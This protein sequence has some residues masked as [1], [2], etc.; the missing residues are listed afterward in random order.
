VKL[1]A[2]VAILGEGLDMTY[3]DGSEKK[4][5]KLH[6]YAVCAG[7]DG[8]TL[9]IWPYPKRESAK[10]PDQV[11]RA[12]KLFE[13]WS[14]LEAGTVN[15]GRPRLGPTVERLGRIKSIGYRSNKWTGKSQ[16]YQHEYESAPVLVRSG[17][18]YRVSGG[19]QRVT[20]RGIVG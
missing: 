20:P 13:S 1:P 2:S 19:K 11:K 9:W 17:E 7:V 16:D 4:L 8:R 12:A 6:G 10:S 5:T 18:V 14:G 15:E 3:V